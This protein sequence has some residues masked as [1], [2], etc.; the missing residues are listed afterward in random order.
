[1]S[2]SHLKSFS[3]VQNSIKH[4]RWRRIFENSQLRAVNCFCKKLHLICF[5]RILNTPL[6]RSSRSEVFCKKGFLK[7]FAKFTGKHLCQSL[8]LNKVAD[9]RPVT[10][11]K[12]RLQHGC[13][14]ANFAKF[15]R[16]PFLAEHLRSLLLSRSER[17]NKITS[18]TT[19]IESFPEQM[20]S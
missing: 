18:I 15:L 13:F 10:L 7:N 19:E 4:L 14:P 6:A 1:M 20:F 16:T 5:D 3:E 11:L 2:H 17:F 8:F 12:K 9:L